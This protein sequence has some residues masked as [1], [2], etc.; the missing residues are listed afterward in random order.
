M[1]KMTGYKKTHKLKDI[2][3]D[4]KKTYPKSKIKWPEFSKLCREHNKMVF[5]MLREGGKY[6]MGHR[7]ASLRIIAVKR[8]P[9]TRRKDVEAI[10]KHLEE[11]GKLIDIYFTDD[12]YVRHY[13]EK[14]SCTVK[15]RTYWE[16]KPS[17]G[18]A[19]NRTLLS[20][21]MRAE[22]LTYL[23]FEYH[24][25]SPNERKKNYQTRRLN[26]KAGG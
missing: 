26:A 18:A 21:L 12:F 2:Y 11:T 20:K 5:D 9:T 19:G 10:K 14:S 15:H 3:K 6:D 4:F 25:L 8:N 23:N 16:F 1:T 13:W 24:D 22:P 7:L 17:R